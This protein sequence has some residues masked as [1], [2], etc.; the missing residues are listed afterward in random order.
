MGLGV[1]AAA[2]PVVV[3]TAYTWNRWAFVER[4]RS[5]I[6]RLEKLVRTFRRM[7]ETADRELGQQLVVAKAKQKR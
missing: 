7:E 2:N 3:A 1:L 4:T 6:A 5:E